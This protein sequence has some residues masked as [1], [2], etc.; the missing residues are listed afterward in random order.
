MNKKNI[1]VLSVCLA[2]IL[3]SCSVPRA[4]GPYRI[5]K[6]NAKKESS[7][8]E[9]KSKEVVREESFKL[10]SSDDVDKINTY[11]VV[12]GSFSKRANANNLKN[13]QRPAYSPVIVVNENGM[14]RVILISYSQYEK[15]KA[16]IA[17][18][19]DEFPDAWVLV[20]KK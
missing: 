12:I 19:I 20:Q 17:Q 9:V 1:I 2:M 8:I 10:D 15:A 13:S 3:A 14:Y 7:K 4:T 18:I 6:S 16:K 5:A 11:N